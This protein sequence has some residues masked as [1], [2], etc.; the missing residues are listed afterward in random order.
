MKNAVSESAFF[1]LKSNTRI[2]GSGTLF[3]KSSTPLVLNHRLFEINDARN[4]VIDGITFDSDTTF[5]I[6]VEFANFGTESYVYMIGSSDNS[7]NTIRIRNCQFHRSLGSCVYTELTEKKTKYKNISVEN[8]Q[9][10]TT[11]SHGIGFNYTTDSII[12]G[13]YGYDIGNVIFQDLSKEPGLLVDLSGGCK[14]CI[15]D[16]NTV[17]FCRTGFKTQND[18]KGVGVPEHCIFSNNLV[19]NIKDETNGYGIQILGRFIQC[20]GN[21]IDIENTSEQINGIEISSDSTEYCVVSSNTIHV[22]YGFGINGRLVIDYNTRKHNVINNNTITASRV[23]INLQAGND[24]TT[25][26]GNAIFST[27]RAISCATRYCTISGNS[28]RKSGSTDN[29]IHLGNMP[30]DH[31]K[32]EYHIVITNNIIECSASDDIGTGIFSY[33]NLAYSSISSNK[34]KVYGDGIRMDGGALRTSIANNFIQVLDSF[35]GAKSIRNIIWKFEY[36]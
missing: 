5:D 11:G 14:H 35:F 27:D 25:I 13:C 4:I 24:H 34:I 23:G 21:T 28:L 30:V 15:V 26:T 22:P 3:V 32:K 1:N 18:E 12:Q 20:I 16:S 2:F 9:F 33:E 8:C 17:N 29:C 36:C 7:V 19:R 31:P 6:N 10:F